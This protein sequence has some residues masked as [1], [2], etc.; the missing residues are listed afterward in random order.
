MA[1][2]AKWEEGLWLGHT[3]S[4]N[5][6]L[7]GTADGIEKAYAIRRRPLEE[8]W[9]NDMVLNLKAIPKGWNTEE[10]VTYE[11]P[12]TVE[13]DGE[14]PSEEEEEEKYSHE[15]RLRTN[16]F[17]RHGLTHECPGCI[18]IRRGAKPPYRHNYPCKKR[19]YDITK[20]E[21]PRGGEDI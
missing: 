20:R 1:M 2:E 16:D 14:P 17:K 3:R 9:D 13:S 11:H 15:V 19:M 18:R 6:V 4:S 8:R 5:D 12:I 7:I 10:A 21:N